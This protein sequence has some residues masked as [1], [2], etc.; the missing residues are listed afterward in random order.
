MFTRA[1]HWA[2][3]LGEMNSTPSFKTQ[4]KHTI[5]SRGPVNYQVLYAPKTAI[6]IGVK[7]SEA[8]GY[9]HMLYTSTPSLFC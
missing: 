4:Q 2:P 6:Q 1:C 3:L 9:L 7:G 5:E 8:R